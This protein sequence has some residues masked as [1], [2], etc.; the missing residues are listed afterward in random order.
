M[1]C[2]FNT[3]QQNYSVQQTSTLAT[4]TSNN[5][6]YYKWN[7]YEL[8]N[9]S[10]SDRKINSTYFLI[11]P[12][13][14][15]N[16][17]TLKIAPSLTPPYPSYMTSPSSSSASVLGSTDTFTIIN[18]NPTISSSSD[19]PYYM[20][21]QS[22]NYSDATN[23]VTVKP[24]AVQQMISDT[25][26]YFNSNFMNSIDNTIWNVIYNVIIT[27]VIIV[28]LIYLFVKLGAYMKKNQDD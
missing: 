19:S 9:S 2:Q 26:S 28:F 6:Q 8:S 23:T 1:P 14:A 13:Y 3:V 4:P 7:S 5:Y 15:I 20:V 27:V 16:I 24:S 21:C 25:K 11:N 10:S 18:S 17:N 12:K 22:S